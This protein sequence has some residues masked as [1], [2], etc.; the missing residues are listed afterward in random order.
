MLID[1]TPLMGCSHLNGISATYRWDDSDGD[2]DVP[3]LTEELS[4]QPSLESIASESPPTGPQRR[5]GVTA[6]EQYMALVVNGRRV[7]Y[8]AQ[9]LEDSIVF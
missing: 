6:L 4:P 5:E 2:S 7:S 1:I 3:A 8:H 9:V